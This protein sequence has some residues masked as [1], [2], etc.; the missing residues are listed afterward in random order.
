MEITKLQDLCRVCLT[1][2]K[3]MIDLHT[4]LKDVLEDDFPFVFQALGRV[5]KKKI[6]LDTFLPSQICGVCYSLLNLAY[7]FIV[8]FESTDKLLKK[9]FKE[10]DMEEE[11]TQLKKKKAPVELITSDARF[12]VR[13]VV[14]VEEDDSRKPEAFEGFLNNLGNEISAMFVEADGERKEKKIEEPQDH[15]VTITRIEEKRDELSD[16]DYIIN[17]EISK[18]QCEIC[19]KTFK[20]KLYLVRHVRQVHLKEQKCLCPECGHLAETPGRLRYHMDAKHNERRHQCQHC[21]K[22]FISL[23][24]L[25]AH[26]ISH[27]NDRTFLCTICGKSFSYSNALEYHMRAHTGEKRFKCTY[28]PSRFIISSALKRHLLSHTGLRPY[29]CRYCESAFRSSGERKCHEMLHTGERPFHCKHCGK[30]F[31]KTYNL[32]VHLMSHKGK[33]RCE[34]CGKTFIE[35]DYLKSHIKSKHCEQN[36]EQVA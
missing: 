18:N 9:R 6:L 33:H 7:K 20:R 23:G 25:Q 10:I 34:V 19:N 12:D 32:K 15:S 22:R 5:V 11:R 21:E 28:C 27:K 17:E 13:D 16:N 1:Q 36:L 2:S 26:I 31:T 29:K 24:H 3:D 4:T 35:M 14:I 30:G 8:D